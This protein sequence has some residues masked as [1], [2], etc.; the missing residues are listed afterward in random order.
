[1]ISHGNNIENRNKQDNC[2]SLFLNLMPTV[3]MLFSA[4]S[5]VVTTTLLSAPSDCCSRRERFP[6]PVPADVL[7][8]LLFW[9]TSWPV[10]H[11]LSHIFCNLSALVSVKSRKRSTLL[12]PSQICRSA[13]MPYAITYL[14]STITI[15]SSR[16]PEW[17]PSNLNTCET[18]H[19]LS[20]PL[21]AVVATS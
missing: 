9:S 1:M 13:M 2:R 12:E 7:C 3:K 16:V 6:V 10:L 4:S 5:S 18:L 19:Q 15:Y 8:I 14:Y 11:L 21:V 17:L 20:H